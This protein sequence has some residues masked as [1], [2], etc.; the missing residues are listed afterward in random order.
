MEKALIKSRQNLLKQNYLG[1][2]TNYVICIGHY[3]LG[4]QGFLFCAIDLV[5]RNVIG[6]CF[7]DKT[8]GSFD[9]IETLKKII[10]ERSFLPNIQI[11]H[12]DR[13]SLFRNIDY[14]QFLERNHINLTLGSANA[15][16]KQVIERY[17]RTIKNIIR[18]S[19]QPLWKEGQP[20]PLGQ[21]RVDYKKINH[22]VNKAIEQYNDKPHKALYGMS[23]NRM[24]ETLFIHAKSV[25]LVDQVLIPP[26]AKNDNI[27]AAKQIILFKQQVFENYQGSWAQFFIDFKEQVTKGFKTL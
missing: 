27:V 21:K 3:Q 12:S 7:K 23:P 20:D 26:L 16:S 19:F 22:I 25:E 5:A 2:K 10:E 4:Q 6:Y 24:E 17:F 11:M 15:H 18:R 1:S 8:F 13:D 14:S 9:V